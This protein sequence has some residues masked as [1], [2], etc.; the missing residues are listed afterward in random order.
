MSTKEF[1]LMIEKIKK[2]SNYLNKT[3]FLYEC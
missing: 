1:S 2:K 3:A